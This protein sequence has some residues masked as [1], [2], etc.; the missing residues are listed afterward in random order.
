M[1]EKAAL[2][3]LE[4]DADLIVVLIEN[5]GNTQAKGTGFFRTFIFTPRSMKELARAR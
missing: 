3:I 2:L 4:I 1:V 5:I